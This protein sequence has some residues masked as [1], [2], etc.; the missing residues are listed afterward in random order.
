MDI[1]DMATTAESLGC[2]SGRN[3]YSNCS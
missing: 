1:T 2:M 3:F